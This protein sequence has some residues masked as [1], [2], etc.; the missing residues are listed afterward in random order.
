MTATCTAHSPLGT[1]KM[2]RIFFRSITSRGV[3]PRRSSH[4][5]KS[6]SLTSYS[7]LTSKTTISMG[8]NPSVAAL[9][10]LVFNASATASKSE[11]ASTCHHRRCWQ[12]DRPW[13]DGVGA[14]CGMV[15]T[16]LTRNLSS[17][18]P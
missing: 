6:F 14:V 5:I 15:R 10:F 9:F 17:G 18:K 8:R 3:V 4:S 13:R 1:P 11:D 16:E 2:P 7:A 12:F